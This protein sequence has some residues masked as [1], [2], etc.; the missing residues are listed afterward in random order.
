MSIIPLCTIM[1]HLCSLSGR[2]TKM[3]VLFL[4]LR[5]GDD[6]LKQLKL[7]NT[8]ARPRGSTTPIDFLMIPKAQWQITASVI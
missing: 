7:N 8:T 5:L 6:A 2:E 1:I 4:K 3:I